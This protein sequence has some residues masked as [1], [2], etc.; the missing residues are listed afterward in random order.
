MLT[1]ENGRTPDLSGM[2]FG[3]LRVVSF[4]GRVGGRA[5]WACHCDCGNEKTIRAEHLLS[6]AT[7]SCGCLRR[8][9]SH[10]THGLSQTRLCRIWKNMNSRC[11]NPNFPSF[12]AY[13]GRG[14]TICEEWTGPDGLVNFYEWAINSGYDNTLSVDRI[15]V[16][17]GY[18][19]SNC[20]WADARLQATNKTNNV[21]V[22]VNGRSMTV[23]E[24]AETLGISRYTLY[25]RLSKLGWNAADAVKVGAQIC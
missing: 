23:S 24:A 12:K 19:P 21:R 14:I 7:T 16:N 8:E 25:S 9:G 20:R 3:R 11:C 5:T 18:S 1:L 17:A 2:V 13:G 6:G 22:E 15:D 4:A 10:K